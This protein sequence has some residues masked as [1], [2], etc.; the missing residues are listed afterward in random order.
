M[1]LFAV[2]APLLSVTHA[3]DEL[4]CRSSRVASTRTENVPDELPVTEKDVKPPGIQSRLAAL[5]VPTLLRVTVTGFP[6]LFS[7][8]FDSPV[9]SMAY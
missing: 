8:C 1:L 7:E 2:K 4:N 5:L 9:E 6:I 3:G